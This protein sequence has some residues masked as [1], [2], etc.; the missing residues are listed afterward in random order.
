MRRT[1]MRLAL[2]AAAT[3]GM[4]PS[5]AGRVPWTVTLVSTSNRGAVLAIRAG[6][7][8]DEY[9]LTC[10]GRFRCRGDGCPLERGRFRYV[11]GIGHFD[12]VSLQF[13]PKKKTSRRPSCGTPGLFVVDTTSGLVAGAYSCWTGEVG[14][15]LTV[16]DQGRVSFYV[17][18]ACWDYHC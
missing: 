14:A 8:D 12:G 6:C 11:R 13:T 2:L 3:I 1:A 5:A 10:R 7:N 15:N 16:V 17:P 9:P 18:P 4:P